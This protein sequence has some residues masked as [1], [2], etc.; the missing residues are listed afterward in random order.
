[1][2][3]GATLDKK[4][5]NEGQSKYKNSAILILVIA[6]GLLVINFLTH[7]KFLTPSN[8][9]III[10][11]AA[12]PSLIAWGVNFIFAS[13]ITD[14]SA[15]AI[16]VITGTV[17]GTL[18][19]AYGYI[20]MILG[21]VIIGILCVCFNFTVF[22]VTK[23][24][25]WIAG[26]GMTMIYEAIIGY[27]SQL[28]I[29]QGLKVVS[30]HSEMRKFGFMPWIYVA[31][32]VGFLAA[33]IIYNRTSLGLNLRAVG[34]NQEVAKMM[35]INP[36]KALMYGAVVAGF[37]FG[38]AG[39]VKE[40]YAG[41]VLAQTG[42]SSISTIFQPI[43][44]VLLAQALQRYINIII[45]IPIGTCVIASIFNIL[46]LMGVPSGTFQ[47]AM[48]GLIVIVFGIIAQRRIKGVVK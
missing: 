8:I 6:V 12:V 13:D 18:G 27:Y 40:S 4:I 33:Y 24:P 47:E 20:P 22:R 9:A 16:I 37:F 1:M 44:A 3:G 38:F 25:P 35:G 43:A 11:T 45:A 21:S 36:Q 28:R 29:A 31:M 10:S 30:M 32:A 5:S 39:F 41:Y 34:S 46:T 48:L 2:T 15:G 23:I 42:L 17:A 7:G 14:L 19:N 26:L